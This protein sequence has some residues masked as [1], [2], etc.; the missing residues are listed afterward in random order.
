MLGWFRKRRSSA[1]FWDWLSA[2]TSRI[3]ASFRD[4]ER[5]RRAT[6]EEITH[7]FNESYP[8]LDWEITLAP[9]PPWRFSVSA[10]GDRNLFARVEQVVSEAPDILGWTI[11]AFRQ[12]GDLR[13]EITMEGRTL[14]CEDIWCSVEP[15]DGGVNLTLWIGGLSPETEEVLT[16]AALILLDNAV[17]EYD[18][19]T[20]IKQI[21]TCP[22]PPEPCKTYDFFP[23]REL[24]GFLDHQQPTQHA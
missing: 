10:N 11:Q 7:V 2:N 20:K 4:K 12:R 17:G 8:G 13:G 22:L 14:T 16:T 21:G 23:L 6:S 9:S 3:Q 19:A 18:A 24:P 1:G 15:E 5:Q